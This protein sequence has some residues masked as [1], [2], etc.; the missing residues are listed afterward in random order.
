MSDAELFEL[1]DVSVVL[2][3]Q[4][5]PGAPV[6]VA[7]CDKCD[8]EVLD[9]RDEEKNGLVLCRPCARGSG[10]YSAKGGKGE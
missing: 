8:E 4:D 9:M 3:A 10:Y 2:S 1:Q 6:R 5:M 7:R